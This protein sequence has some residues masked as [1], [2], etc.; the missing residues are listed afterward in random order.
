MGN[1]AHIRLVD[2]HA[3][4]DCR[5]DH[6]AVLGEKA[7]LVFGTH[8]AGESGVVGQRPEALFA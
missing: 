1:E 5:D 7:A 2:V 6:Q 8:V 3:E 4:C